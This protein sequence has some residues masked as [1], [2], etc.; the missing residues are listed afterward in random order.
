MIYINLLPLRDAQKKVRLRNQILV[1]VLSLAVVLMTCAGLYTSVSWKISDEKAAIARTRQEIRKL[2]KVIGEVRHFKD[3][4]KELQGK[5]DV[6]AQLKESKFGPVHMLD[7][8]VRAV[9]DK[10]WLTSFKEQDGK[11]NI[12]G[13]GLNEQAVAQFLLKLETSPYYQ[14][15]DLSI[16]EQKSSQGLKSQKFKVSCNTESPQQGSSQIARK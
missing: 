8:L 2:R 3:L 15:V 5:L 12:D 7:E 1:S 4:Q 10:L 9:P 13:V 14:N 16:T 11:I 6:L